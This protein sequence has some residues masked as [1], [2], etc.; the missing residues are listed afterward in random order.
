M[1]HLK[2][3]KQEL[4]EK[5]KLDSLSKNNLIALEK[6]W[7]KDHHDKCENCDRTENLTLD[8]IVP[9]DILRQFGIDTEREFWEEN[10]QTYCRACN[11]FKGNRLDFAN[12]KTKVLLLKLIDKI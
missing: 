3:I 7:L 12:P 4:K 6:A 10:Y 1:I 2:Q 8:H 5:N 9:V 11:Q